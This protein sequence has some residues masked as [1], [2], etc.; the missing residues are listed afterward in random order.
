MENYLDGG[1]GEE[2]S[3]RENREA[4]RSVGFSPRLGVSEGP[5]NL[6][7]SV[8]GSRAVDARA[9]KSDRVLADDELLG[10]CGRRLGRG[11]GRNDLHGQFDVRSRPRGCAICGARTAV[12]PALLSG[13]SGGQ[14]RLAT[15]AGQ[16]GFTA[17]VVTMDTQIPGDRRRESRYGLSP[18]LRLDRRT[19]TKMAPFVT[20]RPRWL[21]GQ[22]REGFKLDLVNARRVGAPDSPNPVEKGLLEWIA[23]PP[24]WADLAWVREVFGGDVLVK[25]VLSPDDARRGWMRARRESSCRTTGD[26]N[27]TASPPL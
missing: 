16:L 6:Q 17:I 21:V 25:G 19:I 10:R 3:L 8:L 27:W 20:T 13:W 24:T 4:F 5:P 2:V 22:A 9:A 15:D 12:V 18:P 14:R 26:A 1:A 11:E 7:T 23:E